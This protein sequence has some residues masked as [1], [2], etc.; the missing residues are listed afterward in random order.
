M[1]VNGI[2][3]EIGSEVAIW[4]Q[5]PE[6]MEQ[7]RGEITAE[8]TDSFTVLGEDTIEYTLLKASYVTTDYVISASAGDGNYLWTL[9]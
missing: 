6:V 4:R 3:I 7:L 5:Y 2:K 1:K 9:V 8:E